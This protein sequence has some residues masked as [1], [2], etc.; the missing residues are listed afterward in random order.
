LE[1][2]FASLSQ[3]KLCGTVAAGDGVVFWMMMPTKK[4]VNGDV[5][6]YYTWKGMVY[7]YSHK[8]FTILLFICLY[9]VLLFLAT[10]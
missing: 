2:G 9:L 7:R 10:L 5:T 4:E 3:F 1:N 8:L 6:A